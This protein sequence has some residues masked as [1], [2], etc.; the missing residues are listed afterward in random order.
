MY[1]W[2]VFACTLPGKEG[3]IQGLAGLAPS[4]QTVGS[5][6][7]KPWPDRKIQ[8]KESSLN[9]QKWKNALDYF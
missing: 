2:S 8:Q 4:S 7:K 3:G 5:L 6:L 1:I 9:S